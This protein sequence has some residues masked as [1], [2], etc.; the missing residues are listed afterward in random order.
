MKKIFLCEDTPEGIFTGIY[1]AWEMGVNETGV[2]VEGYQTM[3]LFAQYEQIETDWELAQKVVRSVKAKISPHVYEQIYRAAL[4]IEEDKAQTI[5]QYMRKAFRMGERIVDALGDKDVL[6]VFEMDRQ[7]AREAHYYLE[8]LRFEELDTGILL[9][10]INPK[11]HVLPL[12]VEHFADRLWLEN[13]II[14][15]TGRGLSSVHMAQK[16]YF[17][18]ND[19]TES[20]LESLPRSQNEQEMDKLWKC[21]FRSI[22]IGER[23]NDVLQRQMLPLRYRKYMN[24]MKQ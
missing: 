15:D 16:G 12:I 18:T 22:A 14:L 24:E 21:F 5:F 6:G 13:W 11:C 19:I 2:E 10:R 20:S 8:F 9:A 7:V 3:S 17:F 1:K 4:S 23:R